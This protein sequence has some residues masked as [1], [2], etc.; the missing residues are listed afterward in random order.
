[1]YGQVHTAAVSGAN[2]G[3]PAEWQRLAG[4]RPAPMLALPAPM[5]A[6]AADGRRG[7]HGRPGSP[8]SG[9]SVEPDQWA[10]RTA[11]RAGAVR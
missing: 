7:G 3:T 10:V 4:G 11:R 9:L 5:L 6:A 2:W 8:L 1:M